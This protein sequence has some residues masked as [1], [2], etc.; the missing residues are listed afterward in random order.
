MERIHEDRRDDRRYPL[1]MN[2]RY[3]VILRGRAPL[4]GSGRTLNISSGGVLFGCDQ[5][6]PAGAFVELS[7][8]WPVLLQGTRP[9]ALL[10][11]GRV[12]RTEHLRIAIKMSRYEFL[13]RPSHP[14]Q[15]AI[16]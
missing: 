13:T 11:V 2:L 12:V 1:E 10:I 15:E 4:E 16:A 5:T 9:L 14:S 7:V 3:K 8:H 6:L